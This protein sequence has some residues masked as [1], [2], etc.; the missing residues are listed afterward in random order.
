[1]TTQNHDNGASPAPDFDS[2]DRQ[3]IDLSDSRVVP[4]HVWDALRQV[5]N[6]L[7]AQNLRLSRQNMGGLQQDAV[8]EGMANHV[9]DT[10]ELLYLLHGRGLLPDNEQAFRQYH[11]HVRSQVTF[12]QNTMGRQLQLPA[13]PATFPY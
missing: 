10:L 1:M 12:L 5:Q 8:L 3:T 9:I 11:R 4:N 13:K 2:F 7:I 6:N